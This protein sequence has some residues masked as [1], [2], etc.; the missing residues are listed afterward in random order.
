MATK[1]PP[2]TVEVNLLPEDDLEQRP[3]GKFLK[4]ALS[5]GKRIVIITE[6]IV[7]LAFLS[8]FWLDTTVADLWDQTTTRKNT[9]E[10]SANFEKKFRSVNERITKVKITQ[11]ATSIITVFDKARSLVPPKITIS[12]MTVGVSQ[13]SLAGSSDEQSLALL[14]GAFRQSPDF[15][16]LTVERVAKA[17]TGFN[18]EFSMKATYVQGK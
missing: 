17:E 16:D 1:N 14:V 13:I 12:Q 11:E 9:L 6:A 4:W 15:S 3:G 8:R 18:I 7:I 2:K 5:W 10:A